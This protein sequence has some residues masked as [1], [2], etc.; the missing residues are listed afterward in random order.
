MHHKSVLIG[1]ALAAV[2]LALLVGARTIAQK[3]EVLRG[4]I[5]D[6]QC[7]KLNADDGKYISSSK[8]CILKC[9]GQGKRLAFVD[10]VGKR[11]LLITNPATVKSNVSDYVEIAGAIDSK[12]GTVQVNSVKFL[13]KADEMCLAPTRKTASKQ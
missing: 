2:A 4:W 11:V 5:S 6:E 8:E 3:T 9:M 10:P 12:A 7:A 13:E 1:L